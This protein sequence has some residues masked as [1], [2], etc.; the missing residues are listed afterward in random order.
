VVVLRCTAD[1]LA[2]GGWPKFAG[3]LGNSGIA[4]RPARVS[5]PEPAAEPPVSPAESA[6]VVDMADSAE[7]DQPVDAADSAEVY[8][9]DSADVGRAA[10]EHG[11]E[12]N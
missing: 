5:E 9:D 11:P 7:G 10:E 4:S 2:E 6:E 8:G 12:E 1:R 3:T